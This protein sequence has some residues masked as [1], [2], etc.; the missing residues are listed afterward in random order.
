MEDPTPTPEA[1]PPSEVADTGAAEAA[2]D[3]PADVH[4]KE[5]DGDEETKWWI[6]R[7][8]KKEA[9]K[10]EV[11]KGLIER[12]AIE[13]LKDY[14]QE[15]ALQNIVDINQRALAEFNAEEK[16]WGYVSLGVGRF[17]QKRLNHIREGLRIPRYAKTLVIDAGY[18]VRLL[19]TGEPPGEK[20]VDINFTEA[21][22]MD[23]WIDN[24][25]I[26]E[27]LFGSVEEALRRL[28]HSLHR[29]LRKST[30]TLPL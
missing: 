26:D 29:Y 25:L 21:P 17:P 13:L 20:V 7:G 27:R 23:Y 11:Q 9:A 1:K 16:K 12:W 10:G 5:G 3:R 30:V 4:S 15:R 18:S 28:R 8:P 19:I 24:E 22:S 2:S 14:R 6:D